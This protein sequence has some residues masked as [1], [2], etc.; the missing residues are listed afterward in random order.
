MCPQPPF[1]PFRRHQLA[2]H[3]HELV[4]HI[5]ILAAHQH[6]VKTNINHPCPYFLTSLA[7][8]PPDN[9]TA[10]QQFVY[11]T[12]NCRLLD[13]WLVQSGLPALPSAKSRMHCSRRPNMSKCRHFSGS[14]NQLVPPHV[15]FN[16]RHL[17]Y[18]LSISCGWITSSLIDLVHWWRQRAVLVSTNARWLL[19]EERSL[20]T[21]CEHFLDVIRWFG[22][23]RPIDLEADRGCVQMLDFVLR[24]LRAQPSEVSLLDV[25][26]PELVQAALDCGQVDVL[27]WWQANLGLVNE[28][29]DSEARIQYSLD[30]KHDLSFTYT[31]CAMDCADSTDVL[32]LV[33]QGK[34]RNRA[35]VHGFGHG[36]SKRNGQY[37]GA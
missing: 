4:Q 14:S 34:R 23:L 20:A 16:Q 30:S 9:Y 15:Q 31:S 5:L 13:W 17:G 3:S 2:H 24:K 35:Q 22:G 25:F 29:G 6:V 32:D 1:Q 8:T 10:L 33:A 12:S 28:Q 27:D 36:S 26:K 18:I 19:C 21:K 37:S 11:L 7:L